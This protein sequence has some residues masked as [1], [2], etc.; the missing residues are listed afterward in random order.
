MVLY[1]SICAQRKRRTIPGYANRRSWIYYTSFVH[2]FDSAV[3]VVEAVVAA[4]GGTISSAAAVAAV[5]VAVVAGNVA[6]LGALDTVAAAA[7]AMGV[8]AACNGHSLDRHY[9]AQGGRND[10]PGYAING[11]QT[12]V[13]AAVV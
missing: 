9:P 8:G 5:A 10:P 11:C 13:A 2:D 7:V 4:L 12:K 6:V 1:G 3:G